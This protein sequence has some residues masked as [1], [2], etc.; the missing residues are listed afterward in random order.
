MSNFT[1]CCGSAAISILVKSLS[2]RTSLRSSMM[3]HTTTLRPTWN[4]RSTN[5]GSI[6]PVFQED[7]DTQLGGSCQANKQC[8]TCAA[9]QAQLS[10]R[11]PD[12]HTNEI[13]RSW[14]HTLASRISNTTQ[15]E[16]YIRARELVKCFRCRAASL[17]N[18]SRWQ[19]TGCPADRAN[20]QESRSINERARF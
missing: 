2:P 11:Q 13:T 1:L 8:Y 7:S 15:D 16:L 6:N 17:E 10:F 14:A 18:S 3:A 19:C 4:R 20:K 12:I 9:K 5:Q